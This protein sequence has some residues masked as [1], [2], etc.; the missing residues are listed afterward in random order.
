M[1]LI[2]KIFLILFL[3]ILFIPISSAKLQG[4][5]PQWRDVTEAPLA[6]RTNSQAV[7]L[8]LIR[9]WDFKK[10]RYKRY[11][12][13]KF[14]IKRC[15]GFLI[16]PQ[17]I[18]TNFHCINHKKLAR[19]VT[20]Y[21]N[22]VKDV[23]ARGRKRIK[24]DEF[25]AHNKDL[26]YA[27]IKCHRKRSI[28]MDKPVTIDA[29]PFNVI[30]GYEGRNNK[31]K[32]KKARP[33]YIIHQQCVGRGCTPYK[34]FQIDRIRETGAKDAKHKADT[35]AGTSGAPVFD[36]KSNRLIALHHEGNPALNQAIPMYKII[37]RFKY[38]S[39][40]DKAYKKLLKDLKYLN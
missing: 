25:I 29:R 9:K 2:N 3:N 13:R 21:F 37:K 11:A 16:A 14:K 22:S 35:L 39:E 5:W 23:P 19:G 40:K 32:N 17:T 31:L 6:I 34:V 8:L 38:L 20:A 28:A 7:A 1:M 24:C 26:D 4:K 18:M 33:M 12:N 10:N 15:T 27:I 30:N 36:L